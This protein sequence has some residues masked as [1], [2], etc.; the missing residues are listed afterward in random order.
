MKTLIIRV[1]ISKKKMLEGLEKNS[2]I[3]KISINS[4][5]LSVTLDITSLIS[6]FVGINVMIT[7]E[8]V[9]K[10]SNSFIAK[11][12]NLFSLKILLFHYLYEREWTKIIVSRNIVKFPK[13]FQE[14]LTISHTSWF[15]EITVVI[16]GRSNF[17]NL[18]L[19]LES[20][21]H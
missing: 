13:Y 10:D 18:D 8:Y 5:I 9:I 1:L 16:T 3:E 20:L 15:F 14:D 19:F 4:W 21:Y 17:E 11:Q 7:I 6:R 12:F 2:F